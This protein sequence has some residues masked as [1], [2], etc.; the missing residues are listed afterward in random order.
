LTDY[1]SFLKPKQFSNP[2]NFGDIYLVQ[3]MKNFGE[4]EA[5]WDTS[6][7]ESGQTE[8]G[9]NHGKKVGKNQCKKVCKTHGKKKWLMQ[10]SRQK[11]WLVQN[12]SLEKSVI[13]GTKK[14]P[15]YI[16]IYIQRCFVDYINEL[17]ARFEPFLCIFIFL[18]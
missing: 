9:K 11:K 4:V 7:T 6:R 1:F 5:F 13:N 2:S 18:F 3:W 16:P 8:V 10:K 14:A 15:S 12:R 17:L